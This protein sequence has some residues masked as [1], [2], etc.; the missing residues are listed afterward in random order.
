MVEVDVVL[1]IVHFLSH[2]WVRLK[3]KINYGVVSPYS[4]EVVTIQHK[5]FKKKKTL[6]I[7][8]LELQKNMECKEAYQEPNLKNDSK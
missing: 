5:I 7:K 3:E 2:E 6:T 1:K 8:I 4:A